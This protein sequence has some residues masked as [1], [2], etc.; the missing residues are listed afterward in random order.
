[1]CEPKMD[2]RNLYPTISKK[3]TNKNIKLM[4]NFISLCNGA[5]YLIDIAENLNVPIW[6]LY[7]IIDKLNEFKLIKIKR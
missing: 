5:T 6:N 7:D 1:M 4:M 3:E 2:K